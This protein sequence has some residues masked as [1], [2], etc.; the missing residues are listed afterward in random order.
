M[1]NR[2]LLGLLAPAAFVLAACETTSTP[3]TTADEPARGL[4]NLNE[5]TDGFDNEIGADI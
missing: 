4:E 1:K 2:I 3:R 5:P